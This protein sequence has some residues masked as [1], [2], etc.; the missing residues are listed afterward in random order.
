MR[1][2]I[3]YGLTRGCWKPGILALAPVTYSTGFMPI[4]WTKRRKFTSF[5]YSKK[6]EVFMKKWIMLLIVM[7]MVIV[8]AQ[9]LFF[10]EYIEGSSNNKALEIFN[11]TGT[12]IDLSSYTIQLSRD[13][14]GWGMYDANTE[15]PGFT[16]Q[17]SGSL[18]AGEVYV[19][20]ADA[21]GTDIISVADVALG[22]PSVCH[23]NGDDAIGLFENGTLIDAV[24]IPTEDPGSAWSVAG[25]SDATEEHTLVRKSSVSNGNTDWA[26][27]AGTNTDD[28]EW[29][30][31]AQNTFDY[32]GFHIW[33][34]SGGENLA[35][36]A[37]AGLDQSVDYGAEV[38]L[39]G[40]GSL[41]PDGS[42]DDYLWSQ[43]SGATVSLTNAN[44]SI[45][46]FTSPSSDQVLSFTLLVTD[47]EGETDIDTVVITVLDLS[48]SAVFFSEYIEGSGQNKALEIFNGTGGTID[49]S[50]Y[51][52]W[53]IANGGDWPEYT[54]EL[55]GSLPEAETYVVCHNDADAA[56]TSVADMLT[57]L[58]HNGND[59]QGLAQNFAGTWILIDVIGTDGD[60][61]GNG[62]AVAGVEDAT[63]DHTLVRKAAIEMGNLDWA[64]SAGTNESDSE[65]IVYDQDTWDYLGSHSQN[66]NAP[67]VA[68]TTVS[69]DFITSST[70]IEVTATITPVDGT[71][72]SAT[73]FYGT[74]GNLLNEAEM[75]PESGDLW[76]G[77]VPSQDGNS[78]L[79]IQVEATD[80]Y[81]NVGESAV[82]SLLVA[83]TTPIEIADIHDEIDLYLDDI[84]TIQGIVTIGSGILNNSNTTAY[85][86]DESGRG[87]N[88]FD[89]DLLPEMD[90]G[91]ELVVVGY[92][93]VY[94]ET[95][96]EIIDFD[97]T[98]LNTGNDIP[99][100]MA[101]SVGGANSSQ[102]EGTLIEFQGD[103]A[104]SYA[105]GGGRTY[106]ITDGTDVTIVRIWDDTGIDTTG[107][108]VGTSWAFLGVG[109]QYYDDYQLLVG[110]EEDIELLSIDANHSLPKEFA[111]LPAFPN[112]FNPSTT[113]KWMLNERGDYKVSAYNL[114]GQKVVTIASGH[115]EPGSFSTIWET[116]NL[117]SGVYFVILSSENRRAVQK[118]MLLR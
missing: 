77:I 88:L 19:L 39:D 15:E 103:I 29:I 55:T 100:P 49:L 24:G 72:S 114:I 13:G 38:T 95:T 106:E 41:D 14:A 96:V 40:S 45:A 11:A 1:E 81:G 97:Y 12:Q 78:L 91:D 64:S 83:S 2:N 104:D 54:V 101:V 57:T 3:T 92:V 85:I 22:Y 34:G 69:P 58:Y 35:P 31:Y 36:I 43:I 10:S 86:Q 48:P 98:R 47:N 82:S 9:G 6:S 60:D 79:E 18:T 65:W 63:K 118:V 70:E 46:T 94:G 80:N 23:F 105:S 17:L 28:S 117:P 30:V 90:R 50:D 52:L 87:L 25:V 59:A 56:M 8:N 116:N 53:Q 4:K 110:Y 66:A 5:R 99:D 51:Q 107:L 102:W 68:I 84:V 61:P 44:S 71:I 37:S 16:Y 42:I 93:E 27:S 115:G 112:P 76:M 67:S 109:S 21:A 62:W 75:W 32:L 74:D 111:L 73:I 113:L 108:Q 33:D 7:S 20:A 89:Y 26:S